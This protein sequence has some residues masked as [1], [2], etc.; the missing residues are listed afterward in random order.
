MKRSALTFVCL[1][2]IATFLSLFFLY[3]LVLA[4]RQGFIKEG[5]LSLYWF[6]RI[7]AN[8]ALLEKIANGLLLA[9]C[10]T[11]LSTLIALPLALLNARTKF[12]GQAI[13]NG[14]LL[15]PLILPPFVGALSV[16]HFWGQFGVINLI[17][18]KIG[19]LGNAPSQWPD[20]L[21]SGLAAV[22]V[23]LSLN[24]FPIMYLNITA[25]IANLDPALIQASRNLGAGRVK[26]FFQ[27]V[28]PLIRPGIFAGGS[29]VFVWS[30][31]D[32]GTPLLVGYSNL[33]PVTIFSALT[34]ADT[35][36]STYSLVFVVLMI[37]VLIYTFGKLSVGR[38][39]IIDSPKGATA[40]EPVKMS[41]TRT[42]LI[43]TTFVG[44]M[45]IAMLPHIGVVMLALSERW[46]TTIIPE[47]FTTRHIAEVLR[48]PETRQ[49][50]FNSFKYASV[51]TVFDVTVGF[52][53]AWMIVR[54]R[55]LAS[56]CL[57][58]LVM[59]PLAVPG[60]VL[61]AG[62]VAM[63]V[64]GSTFEAIGPLR[65]PFLLLVIA[66]SVRR[67]PFVVRGMCAGL[68]QVPI[69]LEQSARNLG[70]S[71]L[72][73][74]MRVTLPLV[75][76]NLVASIVLVFSFSMIEVSDSLVLA[77]LPAHFPITKEIY[78]LAV[79]GGA[80]AQNLAAALGLVSMLVLGSALGIAAILMGKKLGS[81]FRM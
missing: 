33:A 15:V 55:S 41:T 65:D 13:A 5:S 51:A 44:I 20:W 56:V 63:T 60:L 69:S 47:G 7:L 61:A 59:L 17:L 46:V 74:V 62:Y 43:W 3:P 34:S 1:A 16:K 32:I 19:V 22:V 39:L 71:P 40:G 6:G 49:C 58:V 11:L 30:F 10:T 54:Q 12:R 78:N 64:T 27:I 37:A 36:G 75:A 35:S 80:D 18:E 52:L 9:S 76:A 8:R 38:S 23:L 70:A 2:A 66:Y 53:A 24:L 72:G 29:I 28:L 67:L 45:A 73:S 68:E 25:S 26:T 57:D 21:G 50:I 31:T 4:A 77:Q 48:Q 42:L 81:I 14:L 79:I